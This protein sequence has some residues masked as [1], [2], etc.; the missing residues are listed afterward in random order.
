MTFTVIFPSGYLIKSYYG[1]VKLRKKWQNLEV[2][3]GKYT[4]ISSCSFLKENEPQIQFVEMKNLLSQLK[5]VIRCDLLNLVQRQSVS[6]SLYPNSLCPKD[7]L[8]RYTKY[9][10][11]FTCRAVCV[12]STAD[13][14]IENGRVFL[15]WKE[16]RNIV[17]YNY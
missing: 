17:D 5:V 2:I 10:T 1:I 11:E 13:V 3:F 7:H 9:N 4:H 14:K 8:W 12:R 6:Y 15:K 16:Y